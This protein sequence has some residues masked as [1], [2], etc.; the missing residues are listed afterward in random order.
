MFSF[1][2]R[3]WPKPRKAFTLIELLVVIAIIAILIGL[4][5]PAVQKVRE[6]ANRA[7][8]SN[9]LKQLGLAAHNCAD[10]NNGILPPAYTENWVNPAAG[11]MYSGPYLGAT[12]TAFYFLLPYIEQDALFALSGSPP[13]MSVYNNNVHTRMIKTFQ[14]P[15]DPTAQQTTH[16]WGV[17][18]YAVNYQVF[19][20]P[21]HPWGWQWGCMGANNLSTIPDGTS[22]T[23][24]YAEKRAACRGGPNGSNGN[25]WGHGW[26]NADWMPMFANTPVYGGNAWLVPQSRPTNA[27]CNQFQAT[28]F[29]AGGCLVGMGDGSVRNV[30]PSIAQNTWM[31]ALTPNGGEVLPNDW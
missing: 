19:G 13:S 15:S 17:A 27:N 8:S 12:G 21:A 6:A 11:H 31:F 22:N 3:R 1:L 7:T 29:S 30:R 23:I 9:N 26:W 20:N 10:S 28:A 16:G 25:L 18:S 5:L 2:S 4:L 14:S 24:L